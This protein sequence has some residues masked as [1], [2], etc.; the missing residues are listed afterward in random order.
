MKLRVTTTQIFDMDAVQKEIEENENSRE[1]PVWRRFIKEIKQVGY[2]KFFNRKPKNN[3][4]YMIRK[5]FK[6][7]LELNMV[8]LSVDTEHED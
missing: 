4:E 1:R 7:V 6:M 2:W 8:Y 5:R 3:L